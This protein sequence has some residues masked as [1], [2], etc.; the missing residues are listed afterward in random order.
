MSFNQEIYDFIMPTKKCF[1]PQD[2]MEAAGREKLS[3]V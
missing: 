2:V 1:N 3:T